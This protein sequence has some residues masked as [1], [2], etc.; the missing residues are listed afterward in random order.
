M[1]ARRAVIAQRALLSL[2]TFF[3]VLVLGLSPAKAED[4]GLKALETRLDAAWDTWKSVKNYTCVFI[5]QERIDG[6]LLEKQTMTMKFRESPFSMYFKW[7]E[8]P[9]KNRELLFQKGWN[10][11][12]IKAHEG[13][14]LGVVNLNLDPLGS[15]ALDG[16]RHSVLEAG[17]K[18][19]IQQMRDNVKLALS[20]G[21]GSVKD[22]GTQSVHGMSLHC[23]HLTFPKG[24]VKTRVKHDPKKYYSPGYRICIDDK[25]GIPVAMES[26]D[27]KGTRIETYGFKVLKM[28]AGLTAKDFDPDNDKYRF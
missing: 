5:K 15:R 14:L 19:L 4:A 23:Y 3:S 12:E 10:D 22:E 6:E 2:A 16:S 17:I 26:F 8:E 18:L 7:I 24:S 9:Y 21:E 1:H 25:N 13:G 28:N 20:K 11:N 27:A